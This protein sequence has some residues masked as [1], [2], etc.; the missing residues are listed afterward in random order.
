[1]A[2]VVVGGGGVAMRARVRVCVGGKLVL[3]CAR[4][5]LEIGCGQVGARRAPLYATCRH[6]LAQPRQHVHHDSHTSLSLHTLTHTHTNIKKNTP[7]RTQSDLAVL[8]HHGLAVQ[9]SVCDAARVHVQTRWEGGGLG[10]CA[11]GAGPAHA[12]VRQEG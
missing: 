7:H 1:M 11:K 6:A 2:G 5:W 12:Q 8:H 9:I 10:V 4:V 3:R